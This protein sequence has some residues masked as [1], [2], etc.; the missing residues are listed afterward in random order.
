VPIRTAPLLSLVAL[1]GLLAG[2]QR[3]EEVEHYRQLKPEAV[4]KTYFG[5]T[6]PPPVERAPTESDRMFAAIVV[7]EKQ[8]WFFKL[9]GP[10]EAV[11]RQSEA[12]VTLIRSVHFNAAA[13]NGKPA[14][15]L[16]Q[17]WRELPA[18]GTGPA[19]RFATLQI[20]AGEKPLEVAVTSLPLEGIEALLMNINRWRG[21][22]GL[23]PLESKEQFDETINRMK[24]SDGDPALL[25]SLA[26]RFQAGGMGRPPL[27]GV[28]KKELPPGHPS[29]EPKVGSTDAAG[30]SAPS[31]EAPSAPLKFDAPTGWQIG[32]PDAIRSAVW[33][34]KDGSQTAEI[35]V[36]PMP[37]GDLPR[38]INRWRGQLKLPEADEKE[39]AA[40]I[41]PIQIGNESGSYVEIVGPKDATRRETILAVIVP[42][43]DKVW[44]IKLRGDAELAERE[45]P[46]FEAFAKSI[47]FISPK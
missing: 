20:G 13:E 45:K 40:T 11:D 1:A 44:F 38:N 24:T 6:A 4:L 29:I 47:Q 42:Q 28:D 46:R 22:M 10:I 3:A 25:V 5:E 43:P 33:T 15:T 7:H 2:C 21:Q 17:G 27:A 36:T 23:G 8:F 14:W 12:F 31:P 30:P 19:P 41:K 18:S 37:A 39:I 16:P 26:G 32:E 35:S 9:V 34:V